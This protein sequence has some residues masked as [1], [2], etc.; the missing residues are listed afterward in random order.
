MTLAVL[1]SLKGVLDKSCA[2][3]NSRKASYEMTFEPVWEH[4]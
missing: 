1:R 2:Y 4:Y 3:G